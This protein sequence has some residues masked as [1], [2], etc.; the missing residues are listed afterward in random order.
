M[1]NLILCHSKPTDLIGVV[2]NPD[3]MGKDLK[4][5]ETP[6]IVLIDTNGIEGRINAIFAHLWV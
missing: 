4:Y 2:E 6:Y 3:T 1:N 5:G